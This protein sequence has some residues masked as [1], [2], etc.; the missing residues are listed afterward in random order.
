MS[1][2]ERISRAVAI[3]RD[4]GGTVVGRTRLQK[5]AYLLELAKAGAGYTFRYRYYGPYS[6]DLTEDLRAAWAFDRIEEEEKQ[7]TWGGTYSIFSLVDQ[8]GDVDRDRAE[9]AGI[10]AGS[11]A[12]A[13]ELAATAAFLKH[14]EGCS[15]PWQETRNRKPEKATEERLAEGQAVYSRLRNTTLGK[16]LP[17]LS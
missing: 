12:V 7:A 14:E 4:A 13:L 17:D 9:F 11:D 2:D 15:D 10:A 3:I 8:A 5:I 16:H 6:E 1:L